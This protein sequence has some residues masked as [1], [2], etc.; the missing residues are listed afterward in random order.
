[1]VRKARLAK[2][3]FSPLAR[4]SGGMESVIVNSLIP[5]IFQIAGVLAALIIRPVRGLTPAYRFSVPKSLLGM[6][7]QDLFNQQ[8]VKTLK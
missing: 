5:V 1:M 7:R 6:L 2:K 8:K 3:T 4:D